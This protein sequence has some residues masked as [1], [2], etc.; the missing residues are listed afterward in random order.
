[1]KIVFLDKVDSTN[2]YIKRYIDGRED[3]AVAAKEQT[4]GRGT[5]GRSF[6]SAV[7]GLYVTVLRF[8]DRLFAKDAYRIV[9]D[10]AVAVVKTLSAFG[11]DAK[12]KW[13][14]DIFCSGKKICGISTEN[15]LIGDRVDHSMTGIGVNIYNEIP[16]DL[17][18]IA[19][20][21]KQILGRNLDINA[22]LFTLLYNLEQKQ[23]AGL[24]ARYSCVLGKK[25]TVLKRSG[26][27]FD[28]VAKDITEDGRLVLD[29]GEALTSAEIKIKL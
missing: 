11:L 19:I 2:D 3:V 12:I 9:A 25:I 16:S 15:S 1:M 26:E 17:K 18:D 6:S 14:N 22:V 28:A 21:A 29:N 23:E 7:G 27:V 4:N 13:P 20:S 5:K 10:T 24:Y 8:Y